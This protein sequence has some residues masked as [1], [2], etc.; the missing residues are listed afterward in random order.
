MYDEIGSKNV[1]NKYNEFTNIKVLYEFMVWF[2]LLDDGL[3]MIN[4]YVVWLV[5]IVIIA[6][7]KAQQQVVL[8]R[9]QV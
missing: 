3:I 4:I 7:S 2:L 9:K 1:N 8:Y 6:F 5:L